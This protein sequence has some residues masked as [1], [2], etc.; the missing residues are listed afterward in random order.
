MQDGP[1]VTHGQACGEKPDPCSGLCISD[2]PFLEAFPNEHPGSPD[3]HQQVQARCGPI[4]RHHGGLCRPTKLPPGT[5]VLLGSFFLFSTF[6][7]LGQLVDITASQGSCN[8]LLGSLPDRVP[9]LHPVGSYSHQPA[10]D[11]PWPGRDRLPTH[12]LRATGHETNARQGRLVDRQTS[13]E[14][15]HGTRIIT[16]VSQSGPLCRQFTLRLPSQSCS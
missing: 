15:P 2:S 9:P 3:L 12:P 11:R 8:C 10:S 14:W 7:K 6:W 1:N 16:P 4:S 13:A 5:G